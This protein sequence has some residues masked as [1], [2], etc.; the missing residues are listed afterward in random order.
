MYSPNNGDS[1]DAVLRRTTDHSIVLTYTAFHFILFVYAIYLEYTDI[2]QTIYE[3]Y[4]EDMV[5]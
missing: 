4:E 3:D 1:F 2:S 5:G